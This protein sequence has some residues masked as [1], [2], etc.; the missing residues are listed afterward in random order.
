M[1]S[2]QEL[3]KSY[4]SD[5]LFCFVCRETHTQVC[6]ATP[7]TPGE[8]VPCKA[9]FRFPLHQLDYRVSFIFHDSDFAFFFGIFTYFPV[10]WG[11]CW[12]LFFSLSLFYNV[13]P[14]MEVL[15]KGKM[16]ECGRAAQVRIPALPLTGAW[17]SFTALFYISPPQFPNLQNGDQIEPHSE[18][19]MR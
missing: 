10:F 4:H 6:D 1:F 9:L 16:A 2:N 13:S 19:W 15:E 18:D 12:S 14:V 8:D 7:V 11:A 17:P 3:G 5:V